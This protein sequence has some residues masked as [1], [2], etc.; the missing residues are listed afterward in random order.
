V[1]RFAPHDCSV[2]PTRF[3]RRSGTPLPT[4]QSGNSTRT[5]SVLDDSDPTLV[6]AR[7]EGRALTLDDA[8]TY[9]LGEHE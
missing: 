7:S 2:R 5:D 4:G 6:A 9:A 1:K 8:V 3:A